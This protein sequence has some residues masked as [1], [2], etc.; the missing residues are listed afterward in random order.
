[1]VHSIIYSFPTNLRYVLTHE[2]MVHSFNHLLF[3]Y[4]FAVR[5]NTRIY[6]TFNHLLS[7]YEFTVRLNTRIYGTFNRFR[8]KRQ[9]NQ[10]FCVYV[11][12]LIFSIGYFVFVFFFF[13]KYL[14]DYFCIHLVNI[15][16]LH[17]LIRFIS[18]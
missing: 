7:S 9:M 10:W 1:M 8:Y 16:R 15:V 4:K 12:F 13:C 17:N 6:G 2:I 18:T 14:F 5:F 11:F 3:S